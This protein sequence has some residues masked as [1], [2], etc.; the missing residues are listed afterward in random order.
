M[1]IEVYTE[2]QP[3]TSFV[4]ENPLGSSCFFKDNVRVV[5]STQNLKKSSPVTVDCLPP[6]IYPKI[7]KYLRRTDIDNCSLVC[8]RWFA[9]IERNSH[10]LS[11]HHIK[12]LYIEE[13]KECFTVRL[14]SDTVNKQWVYKKNCSLLKDKGRKRRHNDSNIG[15][16]VVKL[17][18]LY[19]YTQPETASFTQYSNVIPVSLWH[20]IEPNQGQAFKKEQH[21]PPSDLVHGLAKSFKNADIDTISFT[22]FRL[23]DAFVEEFS[24]VFDTKS[25]KCQQLILRFIKLKYISVEKF[26]QFMSVFDA[27]CVKLE[28]F[29]DCCGHL[30]SDAVQATFRDRVRTLEISNITPEI[31]PFSDDFVFKFLSKSGVGL[32]RLEDC[33]VNMRS[34]V[35]IIKEWHQS[36]SLLFEKICITVKD[37]TWS[38]FFDNLTI[39]SQEHCD[40][41]TIRHSSL[42]YELRIWTYNNILYMVSEAEP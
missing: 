6:E 12:R 35:K 30:S 22:E 42:L 41:C 31:P 18:T 1:A 36:P 4:S 24:E 13:E 14:R 17:P 39:S 10:I 38:E 32:L 5:H 29:R 19:L 9:Q 7:L 33:N 34:L 23:T 21:T 27:K 37:F 3:S 2:Q 8:K 25:I 26:S 40:Q 20:L 28:W 16:P 11:K 15:M